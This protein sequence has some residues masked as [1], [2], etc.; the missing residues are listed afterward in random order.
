MQTSAGASICAVSAGS[1]RLT[2]ILVTYSKAAFFLLGGMNVSPFIV[3]FRNAATSWSVSSRTL[4]S[5]ASRPFAFR[6]LTTS[7]SPSLSLQAAVSLW[8]I[9]TTS[10][11]VGRVSAHALSDALLKYSKNETTDANKSLSTAYRYRSSLRALR[12]S[13]TSSCCISIASSMA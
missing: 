4:D 2:S 6:S 7:Q 5:S 9:G 11:R 8:Y 10:C 3:G 13:C 12:M 1:S